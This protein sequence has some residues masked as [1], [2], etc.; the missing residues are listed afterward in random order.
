MRIN[1]KALLLSLSVILVAVV[2]TVGTLAYFTDSDKDVNTFTVGSVGITLDEADVKTD[3]TL[4]TNARVQENKYHLLPGHTYL[5]D[6]T[7]TVDAASGDCYLFVKV[8]NGI[9]AI[10]TKVEADTVAAQMAVKGWK[11]VKDVANVYVYAVGE[12]DTTAVS[13]ET[14]V[15]VFENFTIDGSVDNDTLDN[16]KTDD[17]KT[18]TITVTA[19]AVQKA[20]FESS[21][22]AEIWDTALKDLA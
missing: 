6:P 14:K 18:A 9:K 13:A 19:Y 15:K 2:V 3:G 4:D 21:T 20:G 7:I 16:Y 5:K 1:K 12:A 10:E 11:P 22:P 17:N 8:V